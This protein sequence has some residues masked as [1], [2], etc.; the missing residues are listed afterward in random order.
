MCIRDRKLAGL[1]AQEDARL[2][3]LISDLASDPA[4]TVRQLQVQ[5]TRINAV[6]EQISKLTA[7]ASDQNRTALREAHGRL[8]TA[9]A[10]ALAA[11]VDLF[12]AEPLPDIGS[13]IWRALW[14]AARTYSREAAYP[15]KPFP[16]T[17]PD[18]HCVLCQQSLSE[19][20]ANRL[21]SFEAFV[22]DE[23]K[24]REEEAAAAYDLSLIHI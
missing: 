22:Q 18:A 2:Q 21:S 1:N 11:S 6:I 12:A 20:A 15:D 8:A 24:R 13:D 14:E 4:R 9:R 19:E 16:V 10:A 17:D 5:E 7:A 3:T 23:S